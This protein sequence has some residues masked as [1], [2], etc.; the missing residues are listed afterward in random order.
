MEI[1]LS[2]QR[3]FASGS[4]LMVIFQ[5]HLMFYLLECKVKLLDGLLKKQM[6]VE[7]LDELN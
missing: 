2:I 7:I 1:K 4:R 6:Q 5:I 3:S